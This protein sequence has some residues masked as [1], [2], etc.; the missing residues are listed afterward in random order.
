MS[1]Q[2]V[3]SIGG[4]L[5]EYT[6]SYRVE[7]C[8]IFAS[9]TIRCRRLPPTNYVT[10]R[11]AFPIGL[12]ESTRILG[13]LGSRSGLGLYL[14]RDFVVFF[15]EVVPSRSYRFLPLTRYYVIPSH[16]PISHSPA[17]NIS[18]TGCEI[19]EVMFDVETSMI[20][21]I[22]SVRRIFTVS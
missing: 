18:Y 12:T 19:T 1:D 17:G 5:S 16:I 14:S 7:T 9:T 22:V 8:P 11:F 10:E 3:W 6:R 4:T 2:C 21:L 13:K 15:V 20:T